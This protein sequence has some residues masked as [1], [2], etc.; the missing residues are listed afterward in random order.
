[1]QT[2]AIIVS[3]LAA[4]GALVCWVYGANA[5]LQTLRAVP[6]GQSRLKWL[7]VVNWLFARKHLEGAAAEHAARVNKALVAFITCVMVALS[8]AALASNLSRFS[9]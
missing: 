7:L 6:A 9:R 1:M 2:V 5:Y 4:I 8:A 3:V